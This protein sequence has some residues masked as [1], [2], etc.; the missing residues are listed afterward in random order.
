MLCLIYER[1]GTRGSAQNIVDTLSLFPET[2]IRD[3][4][5]SHGKPPVFGVV[6]RHHPTL[7]V[8]PVVFVLLLLL[9]PSRRKTT[10]LPVL[11]SAWPRCRC[12]V[13]MRLERVT[14]WVFTCRWICPPACLP[15]F[16]CEVGMCAMVRGSLVIAKRLHDLI[17]AFKRSCAPPH[18]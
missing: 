18:D 13:H 2:L 4:S 3:R 5:V 1:I 16:S 11:L 7:C 8:C 10:H 15:A 14:A 12:I 17:D 6:L 9:A